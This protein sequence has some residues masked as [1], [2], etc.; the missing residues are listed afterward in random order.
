[1]LSYLVEA[2][3]K[4]RLTEM[5]QPRPG[6]HEALVRVE[7]VGICGSDVEL[8]AGT[9]DPAFCR[10]PV[11]P[12]HEWS[13]RVEA[14]GADV[15]QDL[16]GRRVAVEGHNYC[17]VCGPCIEGATQRCARYDEFGF[18][19]DGGFAPWVAA[20]ADLCHVMSR[21]SADVAALAEPTACALHAIER[22][23]V[24][25][26]DRVVVIGAGPVGLLAAM[27]AVH[28]GARDVVV[29][30]VRDDVRGVAARIGVSDVVTG[31]PGDIARELG[32][33]LPRGADVVIEAAGQA[34]TQHFGMQILARGGRLALVGLAGERTLAMN[35]D[36]LVLRDA[37]VEA[38]FA[39][40]SAVFGRAASLLDE[41]AIDPRP[42]LTHRFPLTRVDAAFELLR[43]RSAPVVKVVLDP[44]A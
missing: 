8:V 32:L 3:G 39:Y 18:T 21:V 42:L 30:D 10:L 5:P 37:R 4:A 33:R 7:A 27:L 34:S 12:G 22:V 2:P 40:P 29:C 26:A 6:P 28:A 25:S 23:G 1:V 9:R 15:T 36:A 35:L 20:R 16:V 31:T 13:G 19:R 11:V 38:T 24:G 44:H 14:V 41:G 17:G 43:T